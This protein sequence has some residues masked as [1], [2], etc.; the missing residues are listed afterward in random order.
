MASRC[1]GWCGR[2]TD[3]TLDGRVTSYVTDENVG[4]LRSEL[5]ELAAVPHALRS[6]AEVT[7]RLPL[8]VVGAGVALA[9]GGAVAVFFAIRA[10]CSE[11]AGDR[12][13]AVAPSSSPVS[14]SSRGAPA[15]E[16]LVGRIVF[17][18]ER[19]G[20]REIYAV[21]PD[22][23]GLE[24]ITNSPVD[25][26]P[27]PVAPATFGTLL[28]VSAEN[29]ADG[30]HRER[31]GLLELRADGFV[32]RPLAGPSGRMRNPSWLP[33]G[34]RIVL[35][36]D[37]SGFIALELRSLD[38]G[39]AEPL[40]EEKSGSFDPAVS[41]DGS[42]VAFVSS[43]EGDAEI[44]RLDLKTRE[45]LRLTWSRGDDATPLWSPDGRTIAYQSQRGGAF[46]AYV[47][48]A[49]GSHPRPL[50]TADGT[51][52]HGEGK[53]L[54][55]EDLAFSPD[56]SRLA[57][58]VRREGRAGLAVVRVADGTVV[59]HMDRAWHDQGPAW[60]PDGRHLVF[61]SD[62]DGDLELY[63]VRDDG[64]GLRRLTRSPGADWLPRWLGASH[65]PRPAR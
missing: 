42:A 9:L 12:L 48:G 8:G 57:L 22:G 16:A 30:A 14:A 63:L 43:P 61:A 5:D 36:S 24:R 10:S 13:D 53:L 54:A 34:R 35:E 44:Y 39:E 40:T 64:E 59:W 47:M 20:Q 28:T 50:C 18:S 19:D 11:R 65:S 17:V 21:A 38:G 29:R 60:S 62:R 7:R 27:G 49:D 6:R 56:G 31:L 2:A 55:H 52:A 58:V 26:Y 46:R 32:A 25:D 45:L 15:P 33:D 51:C 3:E 37:A 1:G 4:P 41:P 23:S